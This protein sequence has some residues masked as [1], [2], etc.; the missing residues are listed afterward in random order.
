MITLEQDSLVFRFPEVH[1]DAVC[2]ID[3]QRTLRIPD[4]GKD[5]PLPPGLSAFPLRHLDDHAARLPE[6]WRRRG[7]VIMP[8]YQAEAM[9][10]HFGGDGGWRLGDGYPFAVK[11]GTGK[12]NA[13]SGEAWTNG[14]NRD[15]QDYVAVPKQPWLDGYCVEK[16]VIRQFV[17]MKLGEGWSVE[18]QLTGAAKWGGVQ[19]VVYPMKAERYEALMKA[20][21]LE[22]FA[23][24]EVAG[25]FSRAPA[26]A[27]GLA[28]GGRM[29][30]EIYDD[31]YELADYDQR[32]GS[33]CFVTILNSAEWLA[34]AGQRPPMQPPTAKQ[35]AKAGLPWFDYYDADAKALGGAAPFEKV[36]SLGGL[37]K[38]KGGLPAD[39]DEPVAAD[40]V[41]KL[42]PNR[43]AQVREAEL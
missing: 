31:S 5:Y 8:M 30:Q 33:R 2:R 25:M 7:G 15:P 35:Y 19:I 16:G 10:L 6:D 17:A 12:I 41:V 42:G 23:C 24:Q 40:H 9:W 14:L 18:E 1:A 29:K 11:V 38:L 32:R 39:I 43:P 37:A 28:P 27:M 4:D 21:R 13:V 20:R 22:V 34:V 36:K 26:A 3:F